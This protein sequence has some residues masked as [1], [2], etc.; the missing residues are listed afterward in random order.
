MQATPYK[1]GSTSHKVDAREDKELEQL[2]GI[3]QRLRQ[4]KYIE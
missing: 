1:L 2:K 4:L 3:V